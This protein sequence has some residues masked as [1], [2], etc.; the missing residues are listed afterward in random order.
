MVQNILTSEMESSADSIEKDHPYLHKTNLE[1]YST[2]RGVLNRTK[3][4]EADHPK[5][6]SAFTAEKAKNKEI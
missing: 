1:L 2:S 3:R 5:K 6:S 4:V